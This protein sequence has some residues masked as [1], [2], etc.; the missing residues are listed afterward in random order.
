MRAGPE[1]QSGTSCAAGGPPQVAELRAAF[2]VL[3]A[4]VA[5]RIEERRGGPAGRPLGI[6]GDGEGLPSLER[7]AGVGPL[8]ELVTLA[9]LSAAEAVVLVAAVAPLVDERFAVRYGALTDRPSVL[10][11]TGEVACPAAGDG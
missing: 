4:L 1:P 9:G 11:L 5:V 2:E 3:D 10:G 6:E 7:F 8:A